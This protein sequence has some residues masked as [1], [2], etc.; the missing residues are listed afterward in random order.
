MPRQPI[1]NVPATVVWTIGVLVAVHA[2]RSM[3]P[4]ATDETVIL[5]LALVPARYTELLN[6]LPGGVA[7]AIASPV[8]HMMLHGDWLHLLINSAWLLAFGGVMAR[9]IGGL[10]F[11][12]FSLVTGL[13]GAALFLVFNWGQPVPMIGASGA[14]SGLLAGVLRFFFSGIRLGGMEAFNRHARAIPRM[15]VAV[16][17]RDPQILL[18]I[19][20]WIVL[21]FVT[22][23]AGNPFDPAGGIAWEAHLGGF[24]AGLLGFAWFDSGAGP[25]NEP[26]ERPRIVLH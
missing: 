10:R 18:V 23:L 5:S 4:A 13:A 11:L 22:G 21:N 25:R 15:P 20:I 19:G 7:A 1:F 2:V 24:L 12:A 17:L 6:V 16:M 8:T 14:V 26:E 3:L 9:R